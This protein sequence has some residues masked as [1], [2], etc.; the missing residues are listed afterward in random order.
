[1]PDWKA[2]KRDE[3]GFPLMKNGEMN[4]DNKLKYLLLEVNAIHKRIQSLENT[5]KHFLDKND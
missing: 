3:Y 2:T 1:M 4:I 5:I